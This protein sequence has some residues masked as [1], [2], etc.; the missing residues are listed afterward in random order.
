V[1]AT[2]ASRRAVRLGIVLLAA[3]MAFATGWALRSAKDEGDLVAPEGAATLHEARGLAVPRLV[4]ADP[5][6]LRTP[7]PSPTPTSTGATAVAPA[8]A[9]VAPP[10][11]PPSRAPAPQPSAAPGGEQRFGSTGEE[12]SGYFDSER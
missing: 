1:R 6:P 3:A 8:P 12:G 7:R 2:S 11:S 4:G 9:V 10:A 5:G